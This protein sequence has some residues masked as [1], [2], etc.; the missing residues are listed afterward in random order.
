MS[1]AEPVEIS[2][3]FVRKLFDFLLL[4]RNMDLEVA[5]R[6]LPLLALV[7]DEDD[8][9]GNQGYLFAGLPFEVN[10]KFPVV[11]PDAFV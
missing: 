1:F 10:F 9:L 8:V 6:Y 4:I 3:D 2:V 5:A 11:Q 7:A